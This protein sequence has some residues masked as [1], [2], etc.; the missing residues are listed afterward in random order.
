MTRIISKR[1]PIVNGD[2]DRAWL[3]DQLPRAKRPNALLEVALQP[4]PIYRIALQTW[5]SVDTLIDFLLGDD[6]LTP[7]ELQNLSNVLD[8][9]D[10][11][12]STAF[13]TKEDLSTTAKEDEEIDEDYKAW[14]VI[15]DL[16]DHLLYSDI[17]PSCA[18]FA[19]GKAYDLA[20]DHPI[21]LGPYDKPR[22]KRIT[23]R[24]R[25]AA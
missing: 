5:V 23:R 18:V 9:F 19:A 3:V 4:L 22:S 17:V 13:L 20:G 14:P 7:L 6:D 16:I 12:G 21:D 11:G 25:K 24:R 8:L 15:G 10:G 1:Y 2:I